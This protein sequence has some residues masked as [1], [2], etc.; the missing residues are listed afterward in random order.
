ME[1][2]HILS[3]RVNKAVLTAIEE[4]CEKKN[5]SM[6]RS[7]SAT[8]CQSLQQAILN[9]LKT[10]EWLSK[11]VIQSS[12]SSQ[13]ERF[14]SIL[15]AL[16]LLINRSRSVDEVING[17]SELSGEKDK[18]AF[19]SWLNDME[20]SGRPLRVDEKI[21]LDTFR[22][23]TR[24]TEVNEKAP[25]SSQSAPKLEVNV[26]PRRRGRPPVSTNTSS[27]MSTRQRQKLEY[28]RW[29]AHIEQ[30][31]SWES[32][33]GT[34][35]IPQDTVL[36]VEGES[37]HIRT[38][39]EGQRKLMD[40][41][42][43]NDPEKYDILSTMA[44]RGLWISDEVE[45]SSQG[46]IPVRNSTMRTDGGADFSDEIAF[47]MEHIMDQN[48][49]IA[50]R[51]VAIQHLSSETKSSSSLSSSLV[52]AHG[53]QKRSISSSER[54]PRSSGCSPPSKLSK[55][56]EE[57]AQLPPCVPNIPS[58]RLEFA[59][60]NGASTTSASRKIIYQ[61]SMGESDESSSSDFEPH[62]QIESG[63]NVEKK[64]E[65]R[66][67]VVLS[68]IAQAKSSSN[69]EQWSKKTSRKSQGRTGDNSDDCADSF[70]PQNSP[71]AEG[72]EGLFVPRPSAKTAGGAVSYADSYLRPGQYIVFRHSLRNGEKALSIGKV[73]N[74]EVVNGRKEWVIH[75]MDPSNPISFMDSI[76]TP[77]PPK[78][79]HV[80]FS[81]IVACSIHFKSEGKLSEDAR[82]RLTQL[83][84]SLSLPLI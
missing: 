5:L 76:F 45:T 3:E 61:I 21:L 33:N 17:C 54:L 78:R 32:A 69:S 77:S 18:D 48:A 40:N 13:R 27:K 52:E 35:S 74:E 71:A 31:I 73:A 39:L 79:V 6:T 59:K 4:F 56:A 26:P 22:K 20:N 82:F 83:Q 10:H 72:K 12:K 43:H 30:L 38:W 29:M 15:S 37:V 49:V 14:F 51:P 11:M 68:P 55:P 42:Y 62:S 65:E 28:D 80:I 34:L 58:R 70:S 63:P 16:T 25:A 8:L 84:K 41:Y 36:E 57:M 66:P 1:L 2:T 44:K 46:L 9:Q 7:Q 75:P 81:D 64:V 24:L 47:E 50:K 53:A 60:R 19:K 23:A 67:V